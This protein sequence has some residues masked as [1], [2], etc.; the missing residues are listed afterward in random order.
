M[1]VD[2]TAAFAAFA[3]VMAATPGPSN[4]LLTA[5]AAQVGIVRG[6]PA[7][8]G[9][10]L[11]MALLIFAVS[12]GLGAVLTSV[13]AILVVLRVA[14][15]AFLLWLA[16]HIATSDTMATSSPNPSVRSVGLRAAAAF[17]WINPKSWLAA[18]SAAAFLTPTATATSTNASTSTIPQSLTLAAIFAGVA[19]PSCFAWLAFGAALHRLL[20]GPKAQRTFNLAMST[21]L[22]LSAVALLL[23]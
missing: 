8:L 4:T 6:I 2:Q 22:A 7:L 15:A 20:R 14:G 16:L 12:V 19:L 3:F 10:A 21:L 5:T 18:A 9:V 1:T 23:T 11:G 17:Q 13:P